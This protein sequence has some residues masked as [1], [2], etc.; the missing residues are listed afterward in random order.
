VLAL[1]PDGNTVVIT[2]PVRQVITLE[3]S[4][5]SV[6][7]TFGGVGSHAQFSPDNQ[8]V[9]ISAGNQILVYSAFTGWTS[10]TPATTAGTAANDVAVTVP[11]AGAYF[12]G[13]ITTAR[14][15][16][17]ASTPTTSNGITT[18]SNVF[19]P[20][21]D[22]STA[23]TDRIAATNDGLH[24]L[25]ASV[26]PVPTLSDLRVTIP[27]GAC[28]AVG[29]LQFSNKLSTTILS[30][31]AASAIDGVV[32]ASDSSVAF[33]TFTGSGG[34]LPAYS[35]VPNGQGTTTYVKLSG[36]AT[37]PLAGVFSADNSIFFAGTS[38]DNLVHLIT[39]SS[40]TDASTVA[41][42]LNNP[43]GAA[44]PVNLIVQRPRK[45]T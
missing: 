6:I 5:G 28:P 2:D 33:V 8:T 31:I 39:K 3:N 10:I 15:D 17:A 13:P 20:P 43:A 29:G 25:G 41:P 19:Y 9:Y 4:S 26:T 11:S 42:H 14:G 27:I 32:P 36:A 35:P 16:C 45:T 18:E 12:A 7:S 44:V 38:G 23:I 1:S 30:P 21:A 24:I 37:A 22:S 34:V 40:L